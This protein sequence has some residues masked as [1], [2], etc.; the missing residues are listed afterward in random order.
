[1]ENKKIYYWSPFFSKVATVDA[2]INS[3]ISLKRYHKKTYDVSIINVFGEFKEYEEKLKENNVNLITLKDSKIVKSFSKPGFIRSRF[4][5]IYVFFKYFFSL[6]NLLKKNQPNF[7]I[8]HLITILPLFLIL[9]F[10]FQTK[11]IF[12]ISGYPRL[13]FLRKLF[14]RLAFKKIYKVT[15]PTIE[16]KNRMIKEKITEENKIVLLRDPIVSPKK[17]NILVKEPKDEQFMNYYL[18]IGR[19]TRQKNYSFLIDCFH[20][21]IKKDDKIKLVIIG[22][23]ELKENLEKKIKKLKLNQN[24]F[25]IGYQKNVFKYLKNAKAFVL[26]SLW[27]DPGFV[28]IEAA[29]CNLSI[30]SSNCPNGPSE[31]LNGGKDGFMYQSNNKLDFLSKFNEYLLEDKNQLLLKKIAVKKNSRDFTYFKH[32]IELSKIL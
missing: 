25:L 31:L 1:M 14:W 6:K 4:L 16:T 12:R 5:T 19:L 9:L 24:I 13:N 32:N 23:G 2:V 15:S 11:I 10:K 30:I 29:F 26:S 7:L 22:E 17:I 21:L 18:S 27:E 28:L 3:A 8:I 20:E